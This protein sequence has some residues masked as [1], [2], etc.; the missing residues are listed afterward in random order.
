M[1]IDAIGG[2]FREKNFRRFIWHWIGARLVDVCG[3]ARK[4]CRRLRCFG[5]K[6]RFGAIG[7]TREEESWRPIVRHNG[8]QIDAMCFSLVSHGGSYS[9]NL[10]ACARYRRDALVSNGSDAFV[11][12]GRSC[13][14]RYV[15]VRPD[16]VEDSIRDFDGITYLTLHGQSHTGAVVKELGRRV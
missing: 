7:I 5:P 8:V 9:G 4:G 13:G 16:P 12:G 3:A 11:D 14:F 1:T 6:R 10:R 2:W 15:F